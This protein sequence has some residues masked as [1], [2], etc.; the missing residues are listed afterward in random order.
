M[1]ENPLDS[2]NEN[3][4]VEEALA[5][6]HAKG[7]LPSPAFL[8]R[9]VEVAE[10]AARR[11]DLLA[12]LGGAIIHVSRHLGALHQ[13]EDAAWNAQLKVNDVEYALGLPQGS[14]SQGL[15]G[16]TRDSG[17]SDPTVAARPFAIA[18]PKKTLDN[19]S[20]SLERILEWVTQLIDRADANEKEMLEASRQRI[21]S[22]AT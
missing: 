21:S 22:F 4:W 20:Q 13:I 6:C 5:A 14:V 9:C 3:N 16:K 12:K 19:S 10:E 2:D 11:R 1:T 7:T 17:A 8:K 15:A 18:V